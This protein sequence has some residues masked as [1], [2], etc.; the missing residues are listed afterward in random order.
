MNEFEFKLVTRNPDQ[1]L[2]VHRHENFTPMGPAQ[3]T[4]HFM[5]WN[6]HSR[7]NQWE[8]VCECKQVIFY[9]LATPE[10]V[11]FRKGRTW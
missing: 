2:I 11:P 1:K 6:F 8:A 3:P 5:A 10:D 9:A 7:R 4:P